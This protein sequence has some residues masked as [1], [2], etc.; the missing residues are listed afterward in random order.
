MVVI[1]EVGKRDADE[2]FPGR[3]SQTRI[4]NSVLATSVEHSKE[5]TDRWEKSS[6]T[7]GNLSGAQPFQ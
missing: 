4:C 3:K 1:I 5:K 2:N 7:K 6:S